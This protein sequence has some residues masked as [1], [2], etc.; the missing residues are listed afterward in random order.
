[1]ELKRFHATGQDNYYNQIYIKKFEAFKLFQI[2]L[3]IL[4][5]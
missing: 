1:M 2:N 3:L 4:Q 5:V